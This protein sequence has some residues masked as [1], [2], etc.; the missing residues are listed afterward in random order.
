MA[1]YK[2]NCT[3]LKK[4]VTQ[5]ISEVT[6]IKG[7]KGMTTKQKNACTVLVAALKKTQAA[8]NK[9]DPKCTCKGKTPT[10]G[11]NCL[12]KAVNLCNAAMNAYDN[13]MSG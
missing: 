8:I 6:A 10:T 3:D 13:A 7:A 12:K 4:S 9:C 2:S 11:M 1:Q 5:A